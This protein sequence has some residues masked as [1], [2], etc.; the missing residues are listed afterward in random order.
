MKL[1]IHRA[2][3]KNSKGEPYISGYSLRITKNELELAG[4]EVDDEVI[5]EIS[6]GSI[7]IKKKPSE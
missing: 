2:G 4:I 3:M 1:Q 7:T 6:K 5:K